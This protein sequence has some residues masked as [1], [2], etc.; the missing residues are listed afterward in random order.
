[1]PKRKFRREIN[2]CVCVRKYL[3]RVFVISFHK[4]AIDQLSLIQAK[5]PHFGLSNKTIH[6]LRTLYEFVLTYDCP[7]HGK[8]REKLQR[9]SHARICGQTS[10]QRQ[11][12][13]KYS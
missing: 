8:K 7:Q 3:K 5:L 1:M 10:R 2:L 6:T 12:T 11:S 4:N 9:V 13:P